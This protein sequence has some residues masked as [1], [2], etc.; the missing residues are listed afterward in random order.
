MEVTERGTTTTVD[1]RPL[2]IRRSY[3]ADGI[4]PEAM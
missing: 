2:P 3:S 1:A 4:V